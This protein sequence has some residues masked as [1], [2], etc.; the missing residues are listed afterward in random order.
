M[1]SIS[2]NLHKPCTV[3]TENIRVPICENRFRS[4]SNKTSLENSLLCSSQWCFFFENYG[5]FIAVV[6]AFDKYMHCR[7]IFALSDIFYPIKCHKAQQCL[8]FFP[9]HFPPCQTVTH[10]WKQSS[11]SSNRRSLRDIFES[12]S[13]FVRSR[14][15]SCRVRGLITVLICLAP[16]S[17]VTVSWD[18]VWFVTRRSAGCRF[19]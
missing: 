4:A 12:F 17:G 5:I 2:Q 7:R 16:Y 10:C 14:T 9:C 13:S 6:G 11:S 18:E 15:R 3:L 19:S 8:H 1:Y